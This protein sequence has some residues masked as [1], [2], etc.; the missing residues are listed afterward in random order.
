MTRELISAGWNWI[1]LGLLSNQVTKTNNRWKLSRFSPS[2]SPLAPGT[3]RFNHHL[4]RGLRTGGRLPFLSWCVFCFLF[5]LV[6]YFH[7]HYARCPH[8][9][10]PSCRRH[11]HHHYHV[12]CCH[13][14]I[15]YLFKKYEINVFYLSITVYIPRGLGTVWDVGTCFSVRVRLRGVRTCF[16]YGYGAGTV[17]VRYGYDTWVCSVVASYRN[18]RARPCT[19]PVFTKCGTISNMWC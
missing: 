5:N 6:V 7:L 8:H 1:N 12:L 18:G 9:C 11:R 13:Q 4:V 16:G 19:V 3:P 15:P 14:D 17:W 10:C 2:P